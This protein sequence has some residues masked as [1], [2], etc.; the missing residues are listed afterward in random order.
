M[1]V[2]EYL[3]TSFED[4]ARSVVSGELVSGWIPHKREQLSEDMLCSFPQLALP[5]DKHLPPHTTQLAN[6]QPIPLFVT[7]ELRSPETRVR[8]RK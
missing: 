3:R 2:E 6:V 8:G 1:G 4:A 7:L 5:D